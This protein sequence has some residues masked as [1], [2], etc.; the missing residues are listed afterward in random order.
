MLPLKSQRS[1]MKNAKR[2][3]RTRVRMSLILRAMLERGELDAVI[4]QVFNHEVRPTDVV[5]YREGLHWVKHPELT[6]R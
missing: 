1:R 5:L 2:Q 6:I 4:V 3:V